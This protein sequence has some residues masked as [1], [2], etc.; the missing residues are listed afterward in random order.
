MTNQNAK[1]FCESCGAEVP[2]NAK[3]CKK[4]GR[5]FSSVRCPNCGATGSPDKFTNGCPAC[6]YT[7]E[8]SPSEN[9]TKGKKTISAKAKRNFRRA[10]KDTAA[11]FGGNFSRNDDSLPFW[12]YVL[13]GL[14]LLGLLF[15]IM[16]Y[17]GR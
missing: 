1:F 4:C 7:V 15:F 13:T 10:I 12:I 9:L 2:R 17:F 3:M 11:S 14:F 5:F 6:G 16:H 8:G